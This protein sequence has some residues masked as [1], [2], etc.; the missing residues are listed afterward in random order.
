MDFNLSD[1]AIFLGMVFIASFLLVQS[2][3]IPTFGENRKAH[4][5]LR[6]RLQSVADS[7]DMN[8]AVALLRSRKHAKLSP[9]QR[10][11]Q[12]LPGM[13]SLDQLID[14]AGKEGLGYK[15]VV[16]CLTF[17]L[18]G[19]LIVNALSSNPVMALMAAV[20]LGG[21][22]ILSLHRAR[23]LRLAKFEEQLPDALVIMS[24]ALKAG[25]PFVDALNL[26]AVE[27]KE[28]IGPEFHKVFTEINYGGE[29]RH[30]LNG[31]MA[32][33]GSVTVMVFVTSVLIQKETGGNLAELLE[34]LASVIRERFRF[35]RKLRTLSAE[36][37]LAAWILSLLPFGLAGVL[38]VVSPDFLPM[39][40]DNPKGRHLVGVA[41]VL[42]V[43]GILWMR[44]IVRIDV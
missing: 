7:A 28:P 25:H 39:L 8:E 40:V 43:T 23:A 30:A 5:R 21:M 26:V 33:V 9:L 31:L 32:R 10:R 16:K 36:G 3:I 18:L 2:F 20:A 1:Q 44:K 6:Q 19:G 42:T 34:S 15:L 41:F 22:P 24:R 37:R 13:N 12:A 17:A 4:K 29:L 27:M 14:Q 38:T 35:H 11:L